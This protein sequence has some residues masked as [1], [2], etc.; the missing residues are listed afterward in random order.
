[1]GNPLDVG[2]ECRDSSSSS[3]GSRGNAS[4]S[5]VHL[6]RTCPRAAP[7]CVC[8]YC[9]TRK[10]SAKRLARETYG[11]PESTCLALD[12]KRIL[13]P[14]WDL[15]KSD[16]LQ[17]IEAWQR[18]LDAA[19]PS[20][21]RWWAHNNI[22]SHRLLRSLPYGP[23]PFAEQ[24]A[25]L[26]RGRER[27]ARAIEAGTFRKTRA[28]LVQFNPEGS[29]K[30]IL[31]Y[32][33]QHWADFATIGN[34]GLETG[35]PHAEYLEHLAKFHFVLSPKG[36]A[37]DCPRTWEALYMGVIPVLLKQGAPMDNGL[38][39]G[40]PVLLL[41]R[42]EDLTRDLLLETL[43]TFGK[44]AFDLTERLTVE[45]LWERIVNDRP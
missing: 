8:G 18:R 22:A 21:R 23:G 5:A 20:L 41:D 16:D 40:L 32:A 25:G 30:F 34:G 6:M 3:S 10:E 26:Q 33:K 45:G 4:K 38:F 28:L 2:T 43:R 12:A 1:M 37:L 19:P 24:L 42:W 36:N 31:A 17:P 15:T 27:V 7:L 11:V 14:G 9:E 35:L 13:F 29:R 44:R 39:R